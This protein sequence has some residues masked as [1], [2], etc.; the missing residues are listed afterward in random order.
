MVGDADMLE[1]ADRG[2]L[3]EAAIEQRIVAQ[4]ERDPVL[5]A[6]PRDLRLGVVELLLARA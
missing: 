5:Q 6:E 3:V 4:F 1:H 2:D